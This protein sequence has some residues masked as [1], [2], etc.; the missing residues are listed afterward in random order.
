MRPP[1]RTRAASAGAS[2]RSGLAG[3][4]RRRRRTDRTRPRRG[5]R[6]A[7]T[8]A[9][10]PLAAAFATLAAIACGST[11][12][13]TTRAGAQARSG[14]RQDAGA[15]AV[16]EHR[17]AGAGARSR[18]TAGT[19]AS[20]DASP[21][22]TRARD[23]ATR[24]I[25]AGSTGSHHDGTI[26]SPSAM[27]IGANCACVART[28]SCSAT[29]ARPCGGS[30]RAHGRGRGGQRRRDV[31]GAVEQRG[32]HAHRP[33]A[34]RPPRRARRRAAYSAVVCASRVGDVDRQ[35]A[36]LEQRVA[37]GVGVGR[38]GPEDESAIGHGSSRRAAGQCRQPAALRLARRSSR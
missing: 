14:D 2:R 21:C 12:V 33:R 36:G 32:Q 3:C 38:A 11:S 7:G 9:S 25:A 31:G 17:F 37:P 29:S 10:P 15:A 28:Q 34:G 18:A 30:G 5:P 19:A 16:V 8:R 27:R 35:R 13:P 22:R 24:L 4:W 20:S 6:A 23:R 1:G 26:Q